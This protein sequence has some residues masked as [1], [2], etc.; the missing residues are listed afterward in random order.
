MAADQQAA[1]SGFIPSIVVSTSR[2]E[3]EQAFDHWCG[4]FGGLRQIRASSQSRAAFR[5]GAELWQLGSMVLGK[6]T[7][8]ARQRVRTPVMC[9]RDGFDHW[10]FRVL[11]SGEVVL[12]KSG[13]VERL[14]PG[15]LQFGT[16]R[17]ESDETWSD[18]EWVSLLLARDA[19]PRTSA[20]LE[21]LPKGVL[22]GPSARLFRDFILSLA[23]NVP[24]LATKEVPAIEQAVRTL[25]D[26]TILSSLPDGTTLKSGKAVL[27][28]TLVLR[29]IDR[30]IGS[31]RL[32]P[33]MICD[34]TGVSRSALYRMFDDAGGVAAYIQRRRLQLVLSDLERPETLSEPIAAIAGRW[35]FFCISSFNRAFRRAYG[36]TPREARATAFAQAVGRG[37]A[38]AEPGM[39]QRQT[40]FTDL[41]RTTQFG[42]RVAAED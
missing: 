21:R 19:F 24:D 31:A 39:P 11:L 10:T 13:T 8:P 34:L 16:L 2:M 40:G 1:G 18:G 33:Q 3:P 4:Q 26:T 35:G 20:G 27:Q 37:G 32:N 14:G 36:M 22:H 41:L 28:H 29:V 30:K 25:I 5:A 42:C 7:T 12:R 38:S 15:E 6:M 23:R 9:A 17:D